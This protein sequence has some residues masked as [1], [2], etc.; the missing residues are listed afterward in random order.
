VARSMFS[1]SKRL[2]NSASLRVRTEA[3]D[4]DIRR[5][6]RSRSRMHSRFPSEDVLPRVDN[7]P[8][9]PDR[10]PDWLRDFKSEFRTSCDIKAWKHG[11]LEERLEGKRE[12]TIFP[13][14]KEVLTQ[15]NENRSH[16]QSH[17]DSKMHHLEKDFSGIGQKAHSYFVHN[18]SFEERINQ[19]MKEISESDIPPELAK[20]VKE[21]PKQE[22]PPKETHTSEPS[23]PISKSSSRSPISKLPSQSPISKLPSQSPISKLPSQSP[24]SKLPSQ[25]PVSKP[26]NQSLSKSKSSSSARAHSSPPPK[27]TP[28]KKFP[29][30]PIIMILLVLIFVY[31]TNKVV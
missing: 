15:T 29:V 7:P 11:Q 30:T 28:T 9:T 2:T 17:I 18:K 8:P 31:I 22:P 20:A 3:H 13:D 1:S 14:W 25:S 6:R 23:P 10:Q 16:L 12:G 21:V 4:S 24:I 26:R 19:A 27:R 5:V